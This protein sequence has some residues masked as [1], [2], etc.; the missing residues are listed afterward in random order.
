MSS[1][2]T[3]VPVF[4]FEQV[5]CTKSSEVH[6][7]VIL[8][9]PE[10]ENEKRIPL[11]LSLALDCSGSM[12]GSKL[13]SVQDTVCTLIDHLTE[14]DTVNIIGFSQQVF[15]VIKTLPMTQA[16]KQ[17]AKDKVLALHHMG[18][19][20]LSQAII[21]A[22]E[23]AVTADKDKI[24][25][26]ILLTD[27][28]PSG[29]GITDKP[30]LIKMC[31]EI[32]KSVSLSTFGYGNDYDP[33]L[34]ASM[35]NMGRGN[36]FY[37]EKDEDCRGAFALELG[38]LLSL[39][40]QDIKVTVTPSGNMSIKEFLSGYAFEQTAGYRG[41]TEGK[42]SYTVDDIYVGEKK[43]ALIKFS[44]PSA[45][46]AVCARK[47]SVCA[48]EIDYFDVETKNQVSMRVM[49]KIQY[50]KAG[51]ASKEVNEE[52][53]KQ[54]LMIEAA[55][56]Q[57]EVKDKADAGDYV[58]AR[59]SAL[60]GIQ[61][62]QQ[63]GWF[64]NSKALVDNFSCLAENVGSRFDYATRGLKMATAY[65][66]SYAKGRAGNMGSIGTSYSSSVQQD[67]LK[68]FSSGGNSDGNV[69]SSSSADADDENV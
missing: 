28:L 10:K 44:V 7:D 13:K 32:N 20:N 38:G 63:N 16:N 12:Q 51:K 45:S 4:D 43:H 18:A 54:L 30:T 25:R 55:K 19:T 36:N 29:A 56:I 5:D 22:G 34:L 39:Y 21:M 27:G 3:V 58:G 66:T 52:I 59:T 65:S 14:N 67:M 64:D 2:V 23:Y 37:I 57:K 1:Q 26:I 31:G 17:V 35:A 40:A 9:A 8:S 60:A 69:I 15:D 48:I 42:L 41:I 46:E 62:G 11:H 53:K 68:S 47:T 33:E 50:V 49:A 24:S 6:L 61:L